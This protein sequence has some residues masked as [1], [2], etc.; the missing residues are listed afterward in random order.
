M[1]LSDLDT[2]ILQ[3]GADRSVC[4]P[5]D[6]KITLTLNLGKGEDQHSWEPGTH[7]YEQLQYITSRPCKKPLYMFNCFIF[8]VKNMFVIFMNVCRVSKLSD[9]A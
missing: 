1:R 3:I 2:V 9:P 8:P 5:D 7:G 4:I 6:S